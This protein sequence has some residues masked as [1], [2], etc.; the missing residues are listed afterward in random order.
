M[1]TNLHENDIITNGKEDPEINSGWQVICYYVIAD[2]IRNLP[3]I[4]STLGNTIYF[5]I[6]AQAGILI[7]L[8]CLP[9]VLPYSDI[10]IEWNGTKIFVD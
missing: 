6:L 2:P 1:V 7:R 5:V 3:F 9:P 10:H 4:I 8:L